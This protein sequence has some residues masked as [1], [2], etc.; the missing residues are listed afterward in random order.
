MGQKRSRRVFLR[1]EYKSQSFAKS[2]S[3]SSQV[4]TLSSYCTIRRKKEPK[5]KNTNNKKE[6]NITDGVRGITDEA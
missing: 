4:I 2:K 5:D 6:S 3:S 1:E